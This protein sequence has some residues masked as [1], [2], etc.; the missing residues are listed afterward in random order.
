MTPDRRFYAIIVALVAVVT[1]HHVGEAVAHYHA[2]KDA[3]P[4]YHA[5]FYHPSLLAL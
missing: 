1:W 3:L 2:S 5:T 4:A